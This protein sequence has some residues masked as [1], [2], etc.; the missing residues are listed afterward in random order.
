M[1]MKGYSAFPKALALLEP[2]HHIQDT[3][4]GVLTPLQRSSRCILQPQPTGQL[5]RREAD[6]NLNI[7]IHLFIYTHTHTHTLIYIYIHIY[8]YIYIYIL[9]PYYI[10]EMFQQNP[11]ECLSYSSDR[12]MLVFLSKL[13]TNPK[14]IYIIM[15]SRCWHRFAWPSLAIRPYRPSLPAGLLDNVLCSAFNKVPDFFCTGI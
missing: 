14:I 7:Y 11:V 1:A 5:M 10:N 12:V 4:W 13:K 8:I 15:M 9:F 2:H 6:N 3:R